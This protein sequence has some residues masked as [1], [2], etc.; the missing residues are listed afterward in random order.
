M[1]AASGCLLATHSLAGCT[2]DPVTVEPTPTASTV[3]DGVWAGER[4]I[5]TVTASGATA[6]FECAA[7][8]L[9]EPLSLDPRQRFDVGGTYAAHPGGPESTDSP[10]PESTPAR[11]RGQLVD[12][13][14]VDLTVVLSASGRRLGP[15]S[16]ELGGDEVL[17]RCL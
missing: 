13:T 16:L 11:Y 6:E 4:A 9:D 5:L 10:T 8:R 2:G 1:L 7:G 17:E 14:H 3:P 12:A 15:F